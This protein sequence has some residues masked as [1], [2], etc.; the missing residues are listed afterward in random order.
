MEFQYSMALHVNAICSVYCCIFYSTYANRSLTKSEY[1][2]EFRMNYVLYYAPLACP[3]QVLF[4]DRLCYDESMK[5]RRGF[6]IV[7]L[8]IVI[9]VISILATIVT[10]SYT[11]VQKRG[12]DAIRRQDIENL[13]KALEMYNSDNGPMYTGSSCGSG[14]N[15]SGWVN[16]TYSGYT[17]IVD[18]LVNTGALRDAITSPTNATSCTSGDQKC[19]AYQKTTCVQSGRTVSYL[20]ANL[21]SVAHSSTATDS[22]CDATLDSSYGINYYI[23]VE[24]R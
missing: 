11:G 18:C 12:R 15:G 20:Y 5:S 13:S 21:E 2:G 1:A 19:D 6:T 4:T 10:V 14:G 16:G 8:I 7:E 23:K 24:D 17:K 22:T 9:V 3:V